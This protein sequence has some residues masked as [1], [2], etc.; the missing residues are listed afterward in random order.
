MK[1]DI[2]AAEYDVLE[3]MIESGVIS[4]I[5]K[6]YCEFHSGKMNEEHRTIF[7]KRQESIMDFMRTN[8]IDF[9][10]WH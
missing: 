2:E 3:Y 1:L 10:N 4:K 5:T 7:R 9:E 8:D 6:I